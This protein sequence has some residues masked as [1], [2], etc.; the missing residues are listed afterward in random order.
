MMLIPLRQ[1]IINVFDNSPAYEL[2]ENGRAPVPT[3]PAGMNNA[4]VLGMEAR[5]PGVCAWH[6]NCHFEMVGRR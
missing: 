6:H 3:W 1:A 4:L 5:T 2:G